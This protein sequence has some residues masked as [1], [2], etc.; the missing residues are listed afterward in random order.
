M[1]SLSYIVVNMLINFALLILF[2]RFLVQWAQ[3]DGPAAKAAFRIT[4]LVDVFGHIFPT[5]SKGTV[6]TAALV[7]M[8]LLYFI[9]LSA[10]L[11]ILDRSATAIELFFVGSLS[12]VIKFLDM[13][14]YTIIASI[15]A[16]WI[17]MLVNTSHHLVM[18]V[19]QIADPIIAPFRRFIPPLGM[20]DLSSLA[21]LL[22][23]YFM[24]DALKIIG[25]DILHKL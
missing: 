9:K 17:I 18:L 24:S 19:A 13:L 1:N 12:A 5:A 6:N 10:N 15:V 16:S 3:L 22:I 7:L 23:L 21:A 8:L 11:V 4:R 2:L 25:A 14:R 20:F